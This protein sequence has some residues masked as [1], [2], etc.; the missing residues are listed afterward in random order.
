MKRLSQ[1]SYSPFVLIE[2]SPGAWDAELNMDRIDRAI[3]VLAMESMY[4]WLNPTPTG[5]GEETR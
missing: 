1:L 5:A 2:Y 3:Q 4:P